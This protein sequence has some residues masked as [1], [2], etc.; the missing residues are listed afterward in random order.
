MLLAGHYGRG[1]LGTAALLRDTLL[2]L[3]PASSL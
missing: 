2:A 1:A 3:L